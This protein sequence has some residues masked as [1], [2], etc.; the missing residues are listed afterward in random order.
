MH[1]WDDRVSDAQP[2]IASEKQHTNLL[3]G[4]GGTVLL[5]VDDEHAV[6]Q[7]DAV[8]RGTSAKGHRQHILVLKPWSWPHKIAAV[9]NLSV[10]RSLQQQLCHSASITE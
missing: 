9:C 2:L 6:F 1:G 3:D 4:C 5:R 10:G 7:I 8:V